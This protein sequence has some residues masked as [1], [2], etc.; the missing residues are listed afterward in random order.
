MG[1]FNRKK[2]NTPFLY[3][4]GFKPNDLD[5]DVLTNESKLLT[6]PT[7]ASAFKIISGDLDGLLL[8]GE[9]LDFFYNNPLQSKRQIINSLVHDLIAHG[10][11]YFRIDRNNRTLHYIPY[12]DMQIVE[13]KEDINTLTYEFYN[14]LDSQ[15]YVANSNEILHFKFL[16]DAQGFYGVSP[17]EYLDKVLELEYKSMNLATKNLNNSMFSSGRL[18]ISGQLSSEAKKNL[19]E[20]FAKTNKSGDLMI[21]DDSMSYQEPNN[22]F[23]GFDIL[24]QNRNNVANIA[25]LFGINPERLGAEQTNSSSE[26]LNSQDANYIK[27]Y[28]DLI[29]DEFNR[30]LFD[31]QI[32]FVREEVTA[33]AD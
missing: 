33:N 24:S 26:A 30:K 22:Q 25:A 23:N 19:K 21:L 28:T 29:C 20:E 16:T 27:F 11:S 17:L 18:K 32:E 2:D 7:L 9:G 3:L 14:S 31:N 12:N 5:F 10:N 1:I 8:Q 4:G 13:Y 6:N 15:T